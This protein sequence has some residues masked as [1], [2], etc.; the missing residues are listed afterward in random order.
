[1]NEYLRAEFEG[2]ELGAHL[3]TSPSAR[4]QGKYITRADKEKRF[5]IMVTMDDMRLLP[6]GGD[7]NFCGLGFAGSLNS[8]IDLFDLLTLPAR[9]LE[10]KDRMNILSEIRERETLRSVWVAA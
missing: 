9:S 8:L 6:N 3:F 1:M 4:E 10:A 5:T 7:S 2:E